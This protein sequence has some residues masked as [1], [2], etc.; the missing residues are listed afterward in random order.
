MVTPVIAVGAL[1]GVN[2]PS[3]PP[4]LPKIF[5]YDAAGNTYPHGN[6]IALTGNFQTVTG[7][8]LDAV[9]NTYFC[10]ILSAYSDGALNAAWPAGVYTTYKADPNGYIIWA[11]NHG[12]AVLGIAVDDAGNVYTVGDAVNA[13]GTVYPHTTGGG[14]GAYG[15]RSDYY[16]VRKY[17]SSGVLQW[18]ADHGFSYSNAATYETR[19][20]I[21]YR[22]GFLYIGGKTTQGSMGWGALTK[23]NASTGAVVWRA[24]SSAYEMSTYGIVIDA[25]GT[26]YICGDYRTPPTVSIPDVLQSYNDSGTLL[27]SVEM[28][29]TD[30]GY[31]YGRDI[32]LRN[33]GDAIIVTTRYKYDAD[34]YSY[35]HHFSP[36]LA[37]IE[38]YS[39]VYQTM[40]PRALAIDGDGG[41][42]I[43]SS[44][45]S[46]NTLWKYTANAAALSWSTAP[47]NQS[48]SKLQVYSIAVSV[49]ELPPL[50]IRVL[51]G[52]PSTETANYSL[53]PAL[54]LPIA[55]G[56]PALIR[57]YVGPSL[58]SVFRLYLTG[59][60][61]TI[62]LPLESF[63]VRESETNLSVEAVI[64]APTS[65]LI[66]AI[67][68]RT[69]G[70][71][72]LY[73][74]WRFPDGHEQLDLLASVAFDTLRYD[75]GSR[76]ASA[77][78]TG[79]VAR[80]DVGSTKTRSI[81]GISYRA[82]RDGVRRVRAALD[83]YLHVGD[84]ADLGGGETLVVASRVITCNP[85]FAQL[86]F[87]EDG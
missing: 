85:T 58:P 16:S 14:G 62:E 31:A 86:E 87:S 38:S 54:P 64:P 25:A 4:T 3:G 41:L 2:N 46:F 19:I 39:A 1:S 13:A 32:V 36:A 27:H 80:E 17:N 45:N 84:T 69:T 56:I 78:V 20:P 11:V 33:D 65:T 34:N 48:G 75:L 59:D 5:K 55:L 35:L 18:S 51:L 42:Y 49:V 47:L 37:Y 9:G 29:G 72:Q 71:L 81:V 61:G 63:S 30:G 40:A 82:T 23:M 52:N 12:A 26:I 57:D 22:S 74:G 10:G 60:D 15:A 70:N 50:P 77:T 21:V 83:T 8:A 79:T 68:A 7:I 43:A 44:N 24:A 76:N 66:A 28:V 6:R 67:D 73:R 53:I